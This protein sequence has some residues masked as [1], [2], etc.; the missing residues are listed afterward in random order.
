MRQAGDAVVEP[1]QE[2]VLHDDL[3]VLG[4]YRVSPEALELERQPRFER[5]DV[6]LEGCDQMLAA[7]LGFG[8]GRVIV[9]HQLDEARLG[10]GRR[11]YV[12]ATTK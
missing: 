6:A 3:A 4:L 2:V 12:T 8:G 1:A 11:R 9:E 5:A 10:D 7:L